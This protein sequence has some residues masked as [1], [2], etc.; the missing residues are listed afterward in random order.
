[1]R[2]GKMDIRKIF[3]VNHPL[4]V[5][6]PD[7]N[8]YYK[9]IIQELAED[10]IVIGMPLRNRRRMY[11]DSDATWDFRLTLEDSLYYFRSK[12]LG[13]REEGLLQFFL[14]AWP[15][16]LKRVQ[17]RQYYRLPCS[18]GARYWISSQKWEEP[19]EKAAERLGEPETAIIVDISGGGLQLLAPEGLPVG[20]TLLLAFCLEGKDIKE[21]IYVESK[22]IRMWPYQREQ[23]KW[24][25]HALE[26]VDI[27]ERLRET[28][29]KFIF[30]MMRERMG[31]A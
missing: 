9:S 5:F 16:E 8:I 3:R 6:N 25:R 27:T 22:V 10:Y 13:E 11:L 7:Q 31:Q 19:L 24:F 18:F 15:Y 30:F 23:E 14:I 21:S 1:M 29:V 12:L 28:I 26:Y 4:E 20:T 17:R 2:T